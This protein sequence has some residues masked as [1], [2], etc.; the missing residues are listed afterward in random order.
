MEKKSGRT[1]RREGNTD[2]FEVQIGLRHEYQVWLYGVQALTSS[3]ITAAYSVPHHMFAA[4]HIYSKL[5][6]DP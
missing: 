4:L 6:D 3:R 1:V 5:W 2:L